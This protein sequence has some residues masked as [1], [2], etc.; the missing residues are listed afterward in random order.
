MKRAL[1]AL[2]LLAA[3]AVAEARVCPAMDARAARELGAVSSRY[4]GETEKNLELVFSDA[5]ATARDAVLLFDEADAL[6]GK[7]T[8]V[9]DAH[10][11]YANLEVS[12]LL[13][14]RGPAAALDGFPRRALAA[15]FAG[16]ARTTGVIV[17]E[18]ET[19]VRTLE[20]R[21]M[22]RAQAVSLAQALAKI[23]G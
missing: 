13:A 5:T 16:R 3:P 12:Y 14:H 9:R 21:G 4:I 11:R 15:G 20:V 2:A 8:E 19:G 6:F 17:V 7:R 18:T 1:L 10:D 22:T 23:C